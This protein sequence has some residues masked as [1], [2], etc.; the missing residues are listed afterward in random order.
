MTSQVRSKSLR[1]IAGATNSLQH[2]GRLRCLCGKR[3]RRDAPSAPHHFSLCVP[4]DV[5]SERFFSE[6]SSQGVCYLTTP[7]VQSYRTPCVILLHTLRHLIT[8]PQYLTLRTV[9]NYYYYYTNGIY[10][11][12]QSRA[13]D[14][15]CQETCQ[16]TQSVRCQ[17]RRAE[18]STRKLGDLLSVKACHGKIA[19]CQGLKVV[20][21][22]IFAVDS[23][24]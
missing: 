21:P 13:V 5:L 24:V 22:D 17:G 3:A 16:A 4:I 8:P 18:C 23:T 15:R 6:K 10:I 7:P 20:S 11:E 12:V 1:G 9:R 19:V 14:Q 2:H